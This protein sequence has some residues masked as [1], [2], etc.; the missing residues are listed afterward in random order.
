MWIMA[1]L[2]SIAAMILICSCFCFSFLFFALT[3]FKSPSYRFVRFESAWLLL[4]VAP[5]LYN[6]LSASC[7]WDV[8]KWSHNR[9]CYYMCNLFVS[10]DILLVKLQPSLSLGRDGSYPSSETVV[11]GSAVS[12][13]VKKPLLTAQQCCT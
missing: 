6:L 7:L 3:F 11:G 1:D 12:L 13:T 4:K 5:G 8:F 10:H 2:A 9:W